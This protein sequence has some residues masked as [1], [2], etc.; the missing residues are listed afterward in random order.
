MIPLAELNAKDSGV[1]VDGDLIILARVQVLEVIGTLDE[2]IQSNGLLNKTQEFLGTLNESIQSNGLLN[3]T[4]EVEEIID[5]NG[6][7]V[8]PS[9]VRRN[10]RIYG[11]QIIS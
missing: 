9:Q 11:L 7:Q 10:L 6:F 8:L 3:Q 4:R 5:V 1:L 2:S